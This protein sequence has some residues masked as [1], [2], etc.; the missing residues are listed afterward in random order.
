M[1]PFRACIL[2]GAIGLACTSTTIAGPCWVEGVDAGSLPGNKQ[3]VMGSGS[4]TCIVGELTP[5]VVAAGTDPDLEDL[6]LIQIC[7][8]EDFSAQTFQPPGNASFDTQLWLFDLDG[9]GLLGSDDTS[10]TGSRIAAPSTD[11]T[12]QIIPGPGLYLLGIS[13]KNRNP[14]SGGDP[15]FL[16]DGP[17]EISGPDGPGG[18]GIL[19]QWVGPGQHGNYV[20]AITGA[21]WVDQNCVPAAS[22][23]GLLVMAG[24]LAI[25]GTLAIRGRAAGNSAGTL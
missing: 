13:S 15:I 21:T 20:I 3:D 11:G 18:Q 4:F 22:T 10:N 24:L 25:G 12:G 6:Y 5:V 17:Q 19:D 1:N 8:P 23:W 16:F 14:V 9:R 7:D 2:A